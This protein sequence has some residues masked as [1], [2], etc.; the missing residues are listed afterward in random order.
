MRSLVGRLC[1]QPRE[2]SIPRVYC[3][4]CGAGADESRLLF[5][6]SDTAICDEC[7]DLCHQISR[8]RSRDSEWERLKDF[9]P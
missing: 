2:E 3:H 5:R 4:F 6:F 9:A 7:V 1:R 8:S